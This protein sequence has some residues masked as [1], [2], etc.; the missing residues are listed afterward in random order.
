MSRKR[1]AN[2]VEGPDTHEDTSSTKRRRQYTE[3]D[4]KLAKIYENLAH[5]VTN[6]RIQAAKDLVLELAPDK[7]PSVE[8]VQKVLI[9]LIRG[10]CSSRKAARLGFFVA[11]AE[12]LRQLSN[13]QN[14]S[15]L[16]NDFSVDRVL[17]MVDQYTQP[18]GKVAG[19]V[20]TCL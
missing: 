11:L 5:E 18:E 10:L 8:T 4:S 6:V 12:I 20:R 13:A 16:Q 17:D 7:H 19:Q 14:E 2:S 1:R 15:D 9:R 3:Q